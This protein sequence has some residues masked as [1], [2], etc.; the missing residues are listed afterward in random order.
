MPLKI[1]SCDELLSNHCALFQIKWKFKHVG[2]FQSV[3]A[4]GNEFICPVSI[5]ID[6]RGEKIRRVS[7]Y[8][9]LDDIFSQIGGR[10]NVKDNTITL[11]PGKTPFL[12][13]YACVSECLRLHDIDITVKQFVHLCLCVMGKTR[14]EVMQLLRVSKS[15]VNY[16]QAMLRERFNCHKKSQI[17]EYVGDLNL[18]L[19]LVEGYNIIAEASENNR[20]HLLK[21]EF[22]HYDHKEKVII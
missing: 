15:N 10:P 12:D 8:T 14:G 7:T 1:V 18:T 13:L 17:I 9:D 20:L 5:M 19:M 22:D 2:T 11:A 6:L 4:T 21:K 3:K 16:F